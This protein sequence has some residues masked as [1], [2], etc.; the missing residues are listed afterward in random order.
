VVHD[1]T[2]PVCAGPLIGAAHLHTKTG[3]AA[4]VIEFVQDI[5]RRSNHEGFVAANGEMTTRAGAV[6]TGPFDR[7]VDPQSQ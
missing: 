2:G 4:S 6:C 3:A 1:Q 5:G 7:H